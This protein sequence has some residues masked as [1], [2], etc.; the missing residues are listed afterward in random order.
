MPRVSHETIEKL[1]E[2]INL[3]AGDARSKCAL[4]TET[5]THIVKTAEAQ[6]GAGTATVTRA[7]AEKI[8]ETAAPGDRVSS[9]ALQDRVRRAEG[10]KMANRQNKPEPETPYIAFGEKEILDTARSIQSEKR[11]A[12]RTETISRL[13]DIRTKEAK[14]IQGVYDVIVID[15]P[16][17]MK[18]IERDQRPNQTDFDYP[19]MSEEDLSGLTVPF[20]NDC[21]VWLW[22]THKF[23]PMAFRLFDKWDIKYVCC[24]TWHKPGGFQ[25]IGLP[26]YNCEFAL[27]GRVGSPKFIDTKAFPA[28]FSADRGKHSEKPSEFYNVVRRVTAGRRLDMFNRR[29]IEGF[30]RWGNESE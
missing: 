11:E 22:T 14:A 19:A 21:H 9:G 28:C 4:C 27:Y 26:Q 13:E 7:L 18:K 15:P 23:L 1:N 25:P 20:A 16:W 12:K 8:N 2:F 24:M 6:T 17:P 5:L 10:V 30:D 29:P 3:L